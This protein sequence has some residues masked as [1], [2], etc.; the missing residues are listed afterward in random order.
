[1]IK[2]GTV[3]WGTMRPQDIVPAL[4]RACRSH[5]APGSE[6]RR[7]CDRISDNV[8]Q[9]RLVDSTGL[10]LIEDHPWWASDECHEVTSDLFSALD[11]LAPDGVYFGAHPGDGADFG[12]WNTWYRNEVCRLG[13]ER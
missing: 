13:E 7:R 10:N 1:M 11:D 3:I 9:L 8:A 2:V 6:A 4:L 5:T 12:F